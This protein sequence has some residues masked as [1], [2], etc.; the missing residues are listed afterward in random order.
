M[1][2]INIIGIIMI[3]IGNFWLWETNPDVYYPVFIF[4][5][6]WVFSNK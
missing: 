6:G 1:K 2:P 5:A 3:T 4:V